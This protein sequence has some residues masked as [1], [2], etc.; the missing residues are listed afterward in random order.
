MN[1]TRF[2]FS[3]LDSEWI[4]CSESFGSSVSGDGECVSSN[5]LVLWDTANKTVPRIHRQPVRCTPPV[6]AANLNKQKKN[7]SV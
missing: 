1:C 7:M 6:V 3:N 5:V 2:L 4:G